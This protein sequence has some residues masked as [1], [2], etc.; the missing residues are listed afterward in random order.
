MLRNSG[1]PLPIAKFAD[2]QERDDHGRF[3]GPGGQSIVTDPKDPMASTDAYFDA[4]NERI[5]H[6]TWL[7]SLGFTNRGGREVPDTGRFVGT[8]QAGDEVHIGDV[9]SFGR[10][11]ANDSGLA[12]PL[13]HGNEKDAIVLGTTING[14]LTETASGGRIEL[15]PHEIEQVHESPQVAGSRMERQDVVNEFH[16]LNSSQPLPEKAEFYSLQ[17]AVDANL[18][19]PPSG[20]RPV[21][22]FSEDQER[23]EQ[24][25]FGS[26]S[27]TSRS[28]G[29]RVSEKAEGIVSQAYSDLVA[30]GHAEFGPDIRTAIIDTAG[31]MLH[32]AGYN[33]TE[34]ELKA[35][36]DKVY[37]QGT[38]QPDSEVQPYKEDD[39]AFSALVA[40]DVQYAG[41]KLEDHAGAIR[42]TADTLANTFGEERIAEQLT[43]IAAIV[44]GGGNSLRG[45]AESAG[46]RDAGKVS[47]LVDTINITGA[48]ELERIANEMFESGDD[49][50][51]GFHTLAENVQ[52]HADDVRDAANQAI[53]NF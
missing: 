31:M 24:G 18:G 49:S 47:N 43:A 9:V 46:D 44:E 21:V 10:D 19:L 23:D 30:S 37:G 14:F 36:V 7:Q 40:L 4:H 53:R 20:S 22:K 6:D 45:V 48:G 26:G 16:D 32:D 29:G 8:S 15:F 35:T 1:K 34:A 27:G 33:L 42:S 3:A 17:N 2:D 51:E 12:D 5:A 13:A 39:A 52:A 28:E 38:P 25:R 41:S 11:V 50:D